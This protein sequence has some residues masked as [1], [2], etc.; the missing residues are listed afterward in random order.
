LLFTPV[1][2]GLI[3]LSVS[4]D[5]AYVSLNFPGGVRGLAYALGARG[6]RFANTES[7]W[8]LRPNY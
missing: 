3:I 7:G 5:D 6:L 4:D 8:V 1:V 2:F